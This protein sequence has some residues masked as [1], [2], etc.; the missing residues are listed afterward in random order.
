MLFF[1]DG[2]EKK[3]LREKLDERMQIV[4]DK[5]V[6]SDYTVIDWGITHSFLRFSEVLFEKSRRSV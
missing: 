1:M 4:L 2:E 3:F 5:D 6:T